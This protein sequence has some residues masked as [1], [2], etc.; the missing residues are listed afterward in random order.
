MDRDM[1]G[2]ALSGFRV[3]EL[4]TGVAGAYCGRQFARWGAEVS[5][6]EPAGGSPLRRRAPRV[7]ETSLLWEYVAAGKSSLSLDE[8]CPDGDALMALLR[9]A[10]VFVVDGGDA[11]LARFGLT[12]DGLHADLPDLV[13]AAISPFGR[14]GPFAGLVASELTIQALAGYAHLNGAVGRS[15]LKA[16]GH[17]L[18]YA[19]GV[20]A[21]VGALG[22]LVGR[23]RGGGGFL[24]EAAEFDAIAAIL[25]L[26]RGQ[27]SGTHP[28]RGGGP[29]TG[30][31]AVRCQDGW[32]SFLPP[33]A[34]ERPDFCAV[35]D[36]PEDAWPEPD[37]DLAPAARQ[38]ATMAFLGR[39]AAAKTT[40]HV[41]LGLLKRSI[42][43]GIVSNPA[44]MLKDPQLNAR[45]FFQAFQHPTLGEIAMPGPACHLSRTPPAAPA[46]APAYASGTWTGDQPAAA[47]TRP[48]TRRKPLDGVKLLDCTQAWIGPFAALLMADM[49]AETIKIEYH[50][51]P[52][53]W[54]R[55]SVNPAPV[56]VVRPEET[57]ASP[58]YNS[59]NR[60][61]R[62][63]CLNYREEEA[64]DIFRRLAREADLVMENF[65]PHVMDRHGLAHGELAKINPRLVMTSF[66]GYG[67][68]GPL[69]D[70][71]ANGASIEGNAGWDYFHRYPGET[72]MVMGFYQADAISG[73]QM[74]AAT[75]V[76]LI[77][78]T[79]TGEGQAI[80]GSM[81]EAASGY[82]GE[83]LIDAQ[84]GQEQTPQGNRDPD[85]A[86]NGVYP[87]AG[88]D[89]WIAITAAD[90]LAWARL[91]GVAPA[92]NDARF[93]TAEG[94]LRHQDDLDAAIAAW[95]QT[96]SGQDAMDALQR[97]GVAA[98]VVRSLEEMMACAHLAAR[99][100][101]RPAS[102]A[103]VGDHLYN[104]HPWRFA[105][106]EFGADLPP[107]RLG[108][109]SRLLLTEKLG[110]TDAQVDDLI[111]RNVTGHV[112]L[113]TPTPKKKKAHEEA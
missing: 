82:I 105:G 32:V 49:G 101:Y 33:P 100:W 84:F 99:G 76:A 26:L 53:V 38:A 73:L 75:L 16:P 107:P 85:F 37:P 36:I 60:N 35:L 59:V 113:E 29:A 3:L 65:T 109:H 87:S 28:V 9:G 31:R 14:D 90:D 50:Q 5:I 63:L 57:N 70:Y 88:E 110:Y 46:P 21:F 94:R 69:S 48:S 19:C 102:H 18:A 6:L 23:L 81:L 111:A 58:N 64:R 52:D 79:R 51:R 95:T 106:V 54:R 43:C 40:E 62:S 71:K 7:G 61:K 17:I 96:L 91:V 74:A 47:A 10:D 97:A 77:H 83:A 44:A 25:P 72:P 34:K 20:A 108:E 92:L 104:G 78:Q 2:A 13:I 41:F 24:V 45:G 98:G 112:Y 15:P 67:K 1:Q 68:T 55:W 11:A 56:G 8:A 22:G 4:T 103:D 12:L 27:Y 80:D 42:V 86:P 89:R 30:V 66:S 39:Y 93:A